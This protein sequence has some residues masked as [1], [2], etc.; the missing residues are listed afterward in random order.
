M[1]TIAVITPSVKVIAIFPYSI[2]VKH[3]DAYTMRTP[4]SKI[5]KQGTTGHCIFITIY[6]ETPIILAWLL[7]QKTPNT[8]IVV[9][10]KGIWSIYINEGA[11]MIVIIN[12]WAT[13][14]T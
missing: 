9:G 12:N 5:D 6:K 14:L 8:I 1:N 3:T 2:S 4:D 13:C 10:N 11:I 7:Y